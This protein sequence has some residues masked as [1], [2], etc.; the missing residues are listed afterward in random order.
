MGQARVYDK[1]KNILHYAP[2]TKIKIYVHPYGDMYYELCSKCTEDLKQWLNRDNP[3]S[4]KSK[5][6]QK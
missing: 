4:V 3:F 6:T 1:C 2:D 5:E